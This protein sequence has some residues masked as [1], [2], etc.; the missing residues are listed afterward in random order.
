MMPLDETLI[1]EAC[2]LFC[3]R[4]IPTVIDHVAASVRSPYEIPFAFLDAGTPLGTGQPPASEV[5]P[6][7]RHV[8]LAYA[9]LLQ[10]RPESA[11]IVDEHL[12]LHGS[13][14][15]LLAMFLLGGEFRARLAGYV[16]TITPGVRRVWHVHIPKTA[17]TTFTRTFE[18]AGWAVVNATDLSDPD[19][20]FHDMALVLN[21]SRLRRGVLFTG[22]QSLGRVAPLMLPFDVVLTFLR[23]PLDRAISYFN[24][25]LTRLAED[26]DCAE[27]DTRGFFERG[28]DPTSFERTYDD[29]R[30]LVPNEQCGHLAAE[31]TARAA[32]EQARIAHCELHDHRDVNAVLRDMLRVDEPSRHNVSRPSIDRQSIPRAFARRILAD[33]AEDLALYHA[34]ETL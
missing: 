26:P 14:A 11:E 32:L 30:I 20:T 29:A 21:L 31:R 33:N 2:E 4:R 10:R 9:L 5:T 1:A 25:M 15:S 34:I 3:G 27:A 28:F 12:A 8:E 6:T 23:H 24:Y 13:M 7:A 17:G 16:A 19:Y 18:E 22:H